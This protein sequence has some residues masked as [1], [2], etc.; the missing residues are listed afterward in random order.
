MNGYPV[1]IL[2]STVFHGLI[3]AALFSQNF[4]QVEMT[5]VVT[6]LIMTAMVVSENPQKLKKRLQD[7]RKKLQQR[8]AQEK[9]Q[10]EKEQK[11]RRQ[12]E[13]QHKREEE[14]K[15][16]AKVIAEK[17]AAEEK[18]LQEKLAQEERAR[19]RRQQE[20]LALQQAE[21][22]KIKAHTD[23][24]LAQTY[25]ALIRD[26]IEFNWSVPPS[27]RNGMTVVLKIQLV[28]TGEVVAVNI[29]QSS[30][31]DAYDRSAEQAVRKTKRFTEI[32][33]MP[34]DLF[35]REFRSF[36]L[37]FRPEDLLR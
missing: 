22:A 21:Q 32:K 7:Q 4:N 31:N 25:I 19:Q 2:F 9:K 17:K 37:L 18:A 33:Q 14:A 15:A 13:K 28:P 34:L 35:E 11:Q 24:E 1:A 30:G 26:S 6:P 8:K 16:K 12:E 10:R 36:N 5:K 29:L 20:Q 27:A 3:L 23:Y